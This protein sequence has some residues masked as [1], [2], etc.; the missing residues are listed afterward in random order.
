MLYF[1]GISQKGFKEQKSPLR[2]FKV[3]SISA[4]Q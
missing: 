2:S 3:I 1:R 4:I